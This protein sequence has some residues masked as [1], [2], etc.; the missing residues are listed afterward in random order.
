MG[1]EGGQIA[2]EVCKTFGVSSSSSSSSNQSDIHKSGKGKNI[3][4]LTESELK[5]K[6]DYIKRVQI[7]FLH[8]ALLFHTKKDE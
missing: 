6:I 2:S 5:E 3:D 1:A 8:E 4:Y 7:S